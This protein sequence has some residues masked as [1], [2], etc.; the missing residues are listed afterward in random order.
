MGKNR[1]LFTGKGVSE[2]NVKINI[3]L[4]NKCI[5]ASIE[6]NT[7]LI[8]VSI[9]DIIQGLNCI[10]SNV[11]GI[12]V[13]WDEQEIEIFSKSGVDVIE[14]KIFHEE[15]VNI[16]ASISDT[17]VGALGKGILRNIWNT[18][19]QELFFENGSIEL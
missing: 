3:T 8:E 16:L 2:P 12:I 6:D 10:Y 9:Y 1:A 19:N 11:T 4:M 14:F 15:G 17:N 13:D 7:Y 5:M 18:E